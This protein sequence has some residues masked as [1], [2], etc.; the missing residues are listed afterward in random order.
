MEH[1]VPNLAW[2]DP[3]VAYDLTASL[4]EPHLGE[5]LILNGSGRGNAR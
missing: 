3:I 4:R 5:S 2:Q 1:L